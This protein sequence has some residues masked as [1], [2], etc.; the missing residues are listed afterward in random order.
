MNNFTTCFRLLIVAPLLC[1]VTITRAQPLWKPASSNAGAA[2]FQRTQTALPAEGQFALLEL[3]PVELNR[4]IGSARSIRNPQGQP[5]KRFDLELPLANGESIR[6]E[7]EESSIIDPAI[8]RQVPDLHTYLLRDKQTRSSLGR[9][10]IYR[11]Q[12]SGVIFTPEGS[13]YIHPLNQSDRSTHITYYTR[14]LQVPQAVQCALQENPADLGA[15]G[16][17]AGK[18]NAGD[19]QL[20]TYRLAV[21]A[22][23]EYYQWAGSSQANAL[24]YITISINTVNAIFERDAAIRFTLVTDNSIIY[25]DPATDPYGTTLNGT[26]L[27]ANDNATDLALGSGNYDIGI[28]FNNGWSGGLAQ[29]NSVCTADKGRSA[30]G[31]TFGTGANPTPGP[32]GPVFDA[33]VAHEIA[34]QF[35]AT[36]TMAANNGGCAGNNTAA[37]AWEPGGG[38]TI[39][40]YAG[41]CTGNAYQFNSDLYF[42]A[43][44]MAQISNYATLGNGNSCPLITPLANTAPDVTVA[45]TSYTIPVSTP[46][47]LRASGSDDDANSLTYTWEQMDANLITSSPPD[48][49]ATSGPNFRPLPPSEDPVRY[50]PNLSAVVSATATPYEVL[51]SVSRTMN[52]RVNVRDNAAGAGCNVQED[53][54]VITD[55]AGGPFTVTSQATPVSLT[56]DGS[57]SFTI[58]WNVAGTYAAPFNTS[59]V[60]ILF[61]ADGGSNFIYTL[62]AN[63]AN[64]GTETILVPNIPTAAGRIMI[65]AVGNIFYNVNAAPIS[66]SSSCSAEGATLNPESTVTATPGSASLNLSIAPNFGTVIL[67]TSGAQLTNSDPATTLSVYNSVSMGCITFGNE[68]RYDTYS[69]QVNVS[70]S[71]TLQKTGGA[72]IMNLYSGDFNPSSTCAGF[73][74]SNGTFNGSSVSIAGSISASLVAGVRYTL[75]VGT[76]SS[77]DP[78]KPFAY[79]ISL[80]SAPPGGNL[81][82]GFPDPGPG[83]SYAYIVVNNNTGNIVEIL[84][85]PDLSNA[86]TYA[87][88]VYTVYGFS[89]ATGSFSAGDLDAYEGGAFTALTNDIFSDPAASCGNLSKNEVTVNIFGVLPVEMLPLTAQAEGMQV[90]LRW[91]TAQEFNSL[92][93][94]VERS[95]DGRLFAPIGDLPAAGE[96]TSRRD[97]QWLDLAPEAN[98]NY[99][100]ISAVSADGSVQYS[101]IVFVRILPD[102]FKASL[103][104]NPFANQT[105]LQVHM[106]Q[107]SSLRMQVYNSSG[108]LLKQTQWQLPAGQHRLPLDLSG[109][110]SGTYFVSLELDGEKRLLK[111]V[112][113]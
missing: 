61:S 6:A 40:A 63:T 21:A 48:A 58:N 79:T 68:F 41:T 76:F 102:R 72:Y 101:N 3:D 104:P 47:F 67:P 38:S 28:L 95:M 66:I 17:V 77:A 42:H 34:H 81:Y 78:P 106:P 107:A 29:L 50:L 12:I 109:Q 55:V 82:S 98:G 23:G 43:G 97:Y 94:D 32:Q 70:G 20:R 75:A 74:T 7:A 84:P 53:V 111:M 65:R 85:S 57:N 91:A 96:A 46:F 105:Q 92:R 25:T 33:T 54:T 35:S 88:G 60:D 113:N 36:H 73:I 5:I 71:Y 30:A 112:K 8:Q 103:Y 31:I 2:F 90:R 24:A 14:S 1:F 9:I 64:D 44:N 99:Y 13:S 56:A 52:F 22:T 51:P 93:F 80:N 18:M 19:C 39:M 83:F 110:S 86:A 11:Q 37:S 27:T 4:R 69:F 62:L 59:Q 45:A 16:A 15:A 100:R 10:S 49:T 87:G 108:Q 26:L 89:Y